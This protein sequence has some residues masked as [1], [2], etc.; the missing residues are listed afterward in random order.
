[1]RSF[2][3]PT[4]H[5]L[6]SIKIH[7]SKHRQPDLVSSQPRFLRH[8]LIRTFQQQQ[9]KNECCLYTT[10][11]VCACLSAHTFYIQNMLVTS[12]RTRRKLRVRVLST[13]SCHV[14]HPFWKE[15]LCRGTSGKSRRYKRRMKQMDAPR[16]R[17]EPMRRTQ[18]GTKNLKWTRKRTRLLTLVA[19]TK[20]GRLRGNWTNLVQQQE[21]SRAR[22][23]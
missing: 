17:N 3:H 7:P 21:R 19:W 13:L 5:L 1:M 15:T 22:V 2:H 23:N 4:S 18:K 8:F 6:P 16:A 9:K 11:R 12:Q 14:S 10:R 20:I